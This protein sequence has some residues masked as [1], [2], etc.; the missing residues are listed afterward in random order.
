MTANPAHVTI[1]PPIDIAFLYQVNRIIGE[2]E[3]V[4]SA[5]DALVP[6]IRPYFI[7]DNV[8]YS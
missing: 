6:V 2:S 4:H 3:D 7:F 5:M 8:F 1:F